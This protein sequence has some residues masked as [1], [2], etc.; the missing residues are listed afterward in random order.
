ML[1]TIKSE[2]TIKDLESFSGIKAHTI[3]IWEKR[4]DL[5]TPNRTDSNIRY[6]NVDQLL[7]LLN[8]SILYKNGIKISKIAALS[9]E[10]ILQK[11]RGFLKVKVVHENILLAFKMAM[12]NFNESSFN[13][14]FNEVLASLGFRKVFVEIFIP[15]L[16]E[17][18]N[19]WQLKSITPAH[20]H[21][22]TNLIKQ[23]IHGAIE[24]LNIEEH[25]DK[26]PYVLYL[27]PNE[28]HEIGL[29]YLHYELLSL[30]ERSIYLGQ[31]VPLSNLKDLA[32][33]YSAINYV[34]YLTIEP[35]D[36]EIDDYVSKLKNLALH[37]DQ[38]ILHVMGQKVKDYSL[39]LKHVIPYQG[40]DHFLKVYH[41]EK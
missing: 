31:S 32:S 20:E 11:A 18:G 17:I 12:I 4:Y 36:E 27:P 21:F 33:M 7:K 26:T 24:N 41:G 8:I 22:I 28:I 13:E 23:K 5:L 37:S 40:V 34:T 39:S 30:G 1:N 14:A 2:F 25:L 15:F 6:Y 35:T 3:R 9:N 19:L 10:E 38:S 16:Y 29:L